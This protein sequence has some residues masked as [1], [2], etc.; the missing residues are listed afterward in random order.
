M[1]DG[2]ST[3][4]GGVGFVRTRSVAGVVHAASIGQRVFD[5]LVV[6]L[7]E[8]CRVG[9][10]PRRIGARSVASGGAGAARR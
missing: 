9:A 10:T 1:R 7:R 2:H 6:A 8:C 4:A 5:A 3:F